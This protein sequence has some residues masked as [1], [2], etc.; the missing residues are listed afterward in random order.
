[1]FLLLPLRVLFL[2]GLRVA[3]GA[4]FVDEDDD[5]FEFPYQE[6]VFKETVEVVKET[7]E[8][9]KEANADTGSTEETQDSDFIEIEVTDSDSK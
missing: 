8:T 4:D 2:R 9:V 7:A 1:M 3:D 5:G 6:Q